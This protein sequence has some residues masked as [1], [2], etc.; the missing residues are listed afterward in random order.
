MKLSLSF[1][2]TESYLPSNRHTKVK[3]RVLTTA[4]EFN[5][6]HI[7]LAQFPI[8]F[9]THELRGDNYAGEKYFLND[10]SRIYRAYNDNLFRQL[11]F[12]GDT[13][14]VKA[15]LEAKVSRFNYKTN[16]SILKS[17]IINLIQEKLSHFVVVNEYEVWGISAEPIYEVNYDFSNCAKKAL[18]LFIEDSDKNASQ[19]QFNALQ[20]LD[21]QQLCK[22]EAKDEHLHIGPCA[23]IEVLMPELVKC[24]PQAEYIVSL[25][26]K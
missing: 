6:T 7:D 13:A 1:T 20:K 8:A 14:E 25:L 4:H 5:V 3:E 24:D 16:D 11:T 23:H 21:A 18:A 15:Y 17:D 2:Y 12:C 10:H 22:A 9:I 19:Y 26:A